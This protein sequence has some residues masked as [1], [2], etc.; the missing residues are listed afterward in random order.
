MPVASGY[1]GAVARQLARSVPST[2]SNPQP[3]PEG[4]ERRIDSHGREYFVDH[5]TRT[6]T[7]QDPRNTL[8]ANPS[9]TTSTLAPP[10][11]ISGA[12]PPV[13]P[14]VGQA[15]TTTAPDS[16][17]SRSQMWAQNQMRYQAS[18]TGQAS[19]QPTVVAAPS[20]GV[21]SALASLSQGLPSGWERRI[22][23]FGRVYYID[24]V[25]KVT[26]WVDTRL[27]PISV[28]HLPSGWEVRLLF[29]NRQTNENSF[30]DPRIPLRPGSTS[31]PPLESNWDA[32]WLFI[33]HNTKT[34]HWHPPTPSR[35]FQLKVYHFRAQF[36]LRSGEVP[37]IVRRDRLFEDSY[38]QIMSKSAHEL[39]KHLKIQFVGEQGLDYGGV[40]REWFFL[41]SHEMFNPYYCLFEY[42][43][44]E[45]YTLQINP[46]SSI[47]QNHLDFFK[48]IGRVVGLAVFNGK[49]IDG[50][51]IRPFYK[52]M[53]GQP[54]TLDDMEAVDSEYHRSLKW[55][56]DN[57]ITGVL[58]LNFSVDF[59]QFGAITQVD[60]KPGGKNI[61][62]DESNKKEYV[63]LLVQWRFNRGTDEQMSS[64][65]NGFAE[66]VPLQL[67]KVFDHKEL[68]LVISGVA[69]IDVNDWRRN[70]VYKG[71]YS[72]SSPVVQWFWQAAES[73]DH[74]KRSRLLQFV[75][76]TARVPP[77]GFCALQGANGYQKFTIEKITTHNGLPTSH[78]C[79]N[80]LDL[81]CTYK[82]Y[83]ECYQKLTTAIYETEGFSIQ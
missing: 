32:R 15:G 10:P 12:Q 53:L 49:L 69:Y 13:Q 29:I 26:N 83:Q 14:G 31:L 16:G 37:I 64:F 41:I 56:L 25:S 11:S 67:I 40:A 54:A 47:N 48:F 80:R 66:F 4:W 3:L 28:S 79:F 65:L 81:P 39:K 82:T 62:V 57:D 22:D 60:L 34:T 1:P 72:E 68:E 27:P 19:S 55:I 8:P 43:G 18:P 38:Y 20:S 9:V 71:G 2:S 74:E 24:H 36:Q 17:G 42:S 30:Q 45:T 77:E 70:T 33:D 44:K 76:G 35:D 73:F 51:F 52:R 58:E 6:T 23:Q 7:W 63:D 5:N 78:T 21:P 50:Y 61:V 46:L 75:T 59:E